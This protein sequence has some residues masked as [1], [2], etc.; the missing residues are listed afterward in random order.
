MSGSLALPTAD[1]Q[2]QSKRLTRVL[3]TVAQRPLV[4]RT[5]ESICSQKG[6]WS[7]STRSVEGS[8]SLAVEG[9]V[10]PQWG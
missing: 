8:F 3:F 10:L 9:L 1:K 4:R 2:E 6:L 7:Y 5:A